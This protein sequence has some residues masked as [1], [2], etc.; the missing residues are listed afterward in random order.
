VQV[1]RRG[2]RQPD[3]RP[4]HR[5]DAHAGQ[6]PPGRR[7]QPGAHGAQQP[8]AGHRGAGVRRRPQ[9]AERL[10]ERAAAQVQQ[11]PAPVSVEPFGQG[12]DPGDERQHHHDLPHG[13]V[14][15][16]QRRDQPP[17]LAGGQRAGVAPQRQP[18]VR[19]VPG[20]A[21]SVTPRYRM[22]ATRGR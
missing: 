16:E 1:T 18:R 12:P 4:G 11:Q 17:L 7:Q 2:E 5:P 21:A 14:L 6:A 22:A 3:Q 8:G 19:P 9:V 13:V 10:A 15:D 20:I